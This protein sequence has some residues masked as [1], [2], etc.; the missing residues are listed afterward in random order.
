[1]GKKSY[2][3]RTLLNDDPGIAALERGLISDSD[4]LRGYRAPITEL[5][6]E[7][8][9]ARARAEQVD[10]LE[11]KLRRAEDRIAELMRS[12]A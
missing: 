2:N 4:A 5:I 3:S 11:A 12:N 6:Q 9:L 1:M 8:R 7:V 10:R